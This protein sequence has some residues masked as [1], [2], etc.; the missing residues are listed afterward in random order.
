MQILTETESVVFI[1]QTCFTFDIWSPLVLSD[2][3]SYNNNN[4]GPKCTNSNDQIPRFQIDHHHGPL[5]QQKHKTTAKCQLGFG[6]CESI[7]ND[8]NKF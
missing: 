4:I 6:L 1:F 5:L 7:H 2:W 8:V 3:I